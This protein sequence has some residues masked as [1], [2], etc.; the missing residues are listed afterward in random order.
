[1]DTGRNLAIGVHR[2]VDECRERRRNRQWAEEA[3]AAVAPNCDHSPDYAEGFKEGFADYLYR[4]GSGE[5][6]L[7]APPHYRGTRYQTPEGYRAIQDWFAGYRR[8][9]A[10]AHARGL[11]QWIV[12]PS[13]FEVSSAGR[14]VP[15]PVLPVVLPPAPVEVLPPALLAPLLPA[16]E[17][18]LPHVPP[19]PAPDPQVRQLPPPSGT[20]TLGEPHY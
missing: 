19:P 12:G 8:G 15:P 11:R 13:A 14:T 2:T 20:P 18:A 17:P 16:P 3:W 9:A 1:V 10:D 5:P 6:P 4:G 7:M